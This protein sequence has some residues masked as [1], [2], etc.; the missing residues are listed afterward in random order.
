VRSRRRFIT[1]WA[2][3]L[4]LSA[5][6]LAALWLLVDSSEFADSIRRADP[7]WLLAGAAANLFSDVLRAARWRTLLGKTE[8][9]GL[10]T[11]T[12]I[13]FLSL[14]L[15]AAV[16]LRAGDL[17]RVQVL[18]RR[19]I[20]RMTVLGT[21]A[22]ERLLDLA[23]FAFILAAATL[24]D[25]GK[26][27]AWAALAYALA[28]AVLFVAA[29]AVA[30][31]G[32]RWAAG[33]PPRGLRA[34]AKWQLGWFAHGFRALERPRAAAEA[35]FFSLTSW[36]SEA[37]V[38]VAVLEALDIDASVGAVL[39]VVVVANTVVGIPLTQ[40]SIGPYELSVT[41]VLAQYGVGAGAAAAF[42]VLVHAALVVPIVAAALVSLWALRIGPRDL[43][44]LRPNGQDSS[45]SPFGTDAHAHDRRL[46]R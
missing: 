37:L 27:V 8:H 7:G 33:E 38:Y 35:L 25:A 20:R 28:M 19:G 18:G 36:T 10:G 21:I 5:G 22:A 45:V 13:L 17:A 41:A 6:L 30:R 44:Y 26:A 16:P 43:L 34:R 29:V 1:I 31:R 42:A 11:L 14:G 12:G 39:V 15:N 4:A 32:T 3:Q 2:L 9:A 40:A 23:T 46:V 24:L